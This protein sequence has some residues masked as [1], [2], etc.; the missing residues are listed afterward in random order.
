MKIHYRPH[1]KFGQGNIFA[2]VILF[3]GEGGVPGQ[4]PHLGR[5]PPRQVQHPLQ[6]GTPSWQVHLPGQVH[7]PPP[8]VRYTHP[9]GQVH[10]QTPQAGTPP[11]QVH[12]PLG[13]HTPW[14]VHPR[15]HCML[16][17]T[18]TSGRYASYW[19]AFLF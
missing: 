12:P 1:T 15:E 7:H 18:T 2:P 11:G 5:Y 9:L 19:N 3:T 17:D 8:P 10:P 14:Q 16:G 6:T 4:V 13:R